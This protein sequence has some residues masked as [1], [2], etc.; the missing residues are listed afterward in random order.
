MS[1][2][3]GLFGIVV[4]T[5]IAWLLS[6]DRKHISWFTVIGAIVFQII[7]A[8]FILK[9]PGVDRIFDLIAKGFVKVISFTDFGS[10]F[11]FGSFLS[12]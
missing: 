10:D 9:V 11:L 12:T 4:L 3:H 1:I 8:I 6:T 5:G 7:L 2:L